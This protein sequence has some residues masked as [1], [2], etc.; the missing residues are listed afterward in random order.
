MSVFG[1]VEASA[2]LL[3]CCIRYRDRHA[4]ES[5][6]GVLCYLS[7]SNTTNIITYTDVWHD[8]QGRV[9]NAVLRDCWEEWELEGEMG[10]IQL[11][12]GDST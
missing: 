4:E 8:G 3:R 5:R 9:W 10:V 1:T 7:V 11:Q 2:V 6:E 12:F